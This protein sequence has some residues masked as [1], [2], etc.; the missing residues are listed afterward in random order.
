[1]TTSCE[2]LLENYANVIN[3]EA[4]ATKDV[5]PSILFFAN[6][7]CQG[8]FAPNTAGDFPDTN[9]YSTGTHPLP[10]ASFLSF[11]IPFN[12][13]QVTFRSGSYFLT[14]HGPYTEINTA[15]LVW[16]NDPSVSW[17]TTPPTSFSVDELVAWEGQV[18][19]DFCMGRPA[20]LGEFPLTRFA[21][22]GARCDEFMRNTWCSLS[23]PSGNILTDTCACFK[24]EPEIEA[25]SKAKGVNLGVVCFG[26]RCAT[27]NSY[28]TFSMLTQPCNAIFCEQTVNTSPGVVDTATDQVFCGGQF[29]SAQGKITPNPS[30]TPVEPVSD[31]ASAASLPFYTW[32][33]LA[34]AALLLIV[35]AYLLFAPLHLRPSGQSPASRNRPLVASSRLRPVS[36][37]RALAPLPSLPS[38]PPV[39]PSSS[40]SSLYPGGG[41]GGDLPPWPSLNTF[42]PSSLTEGFSA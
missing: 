25:V 22:H 11:I 7:A 17:A 27:R 12:F 40:S 42:A 34:V 32:I 18:L 28:K 6:V 15:N 20:F 30:V 19:P 4:D 29:Y 36:Q 13:K 41:V 35:V 33:M 39:V 24:E 16:A 14:L 10:L 38:L 26:F 37:P 3:S 8:A 9:T 5:V 23:P 2:A 31:G 1:M 21:P